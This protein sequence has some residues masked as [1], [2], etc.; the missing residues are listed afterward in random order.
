M[1]KEKKQGTK[2]IITIEVSTNEIGP[3]RTLEL[4][5]MLFNNLDRL[6]WDALGSK[7]EENTYKVERLEQVK[8]PTKEPPRNK[9]KI[10]TNWIEQEDCEHD[11]PHCCNGADYRAQNYMNG[12]TNHCPLFFEH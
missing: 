7:V 3:N 1:G 2:Y 11:I 4:E 12:K 8:N 5:S 9:C 6:L 10:C